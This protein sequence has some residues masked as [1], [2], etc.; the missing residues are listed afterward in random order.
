MLQHHV[1]TSL[2]FGLSCKRV[3]SYE[4]N[5]KEVQKFSALILFSCALNKL[6]FRLY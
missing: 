5:G 6:K 4:I 1:M 3:N 2:S